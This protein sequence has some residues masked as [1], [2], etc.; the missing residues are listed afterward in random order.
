[1][2]INPTIEQLRD[3]IRRHEHQYYALDRPEIS[4]AEYDRMMRQLQE[5]ET[6]EPWLVTPD[7]PTQRVGGT[8]AA[9]FATVEHSPP[10]LSLANAF[11]L[12]DLKTWHNRCARRLG[13]DNFAMT[14]ELKFDGLALRLIYRNGRLEQAATRGNGRQG[15]DVTHTVRTIK[16]IPLVLP[17]VHSDIAVRG[18]AYLPIQSF[19]ELNRVR[20]ERGD[21]VYANPRNAAAGAIRQLDP[22]QAAERDLRFWAYSL[23]HVDF[24]HNSHWQ[25]LDMLKRATLPVCQYK[26]REHTVEGIAKFYDWMLA[27]RDNLPF[28]A[29]GIVVK[30][31]DYADQQELGETNHDPRWAIAWKFPAERQ[32]T[33]L[34]RIWVSVGRFGKMTPMADLEP[35]TLDGAVVTNAS[36]HNEGDIHRKDIRAGDMVYVERSGGVIPQ[37]V[38]PVN[39]DPNR[40]TTPFQWPSACPSCGG[41]IS[42]REPG[43]ADRWCLNVDCGSKPVA[44]LKHFVSKDA[45]DID[46]MGRVI[47]EN[48]VGTGLVNP[49]EIFT[50]TVEDLETLDKVGRKTAEKLYENIQAAKQRPMERVLYSLGIFRLGHHVSRLLA[51]RYETMDEVMALT[52]EDLVGIEGIGASIAESVLAGLQSSRV[53]ALVQELRADGVVLEWPREHKEH[54]AGALS[55]QR[56]CVTGTLSGMTRKEAEAAV[57]DHGGE[58]A[59]DVTKSTTLLVVGEKPGSKVA[60][61]ERNGVKIWSEE[62]FAAAIA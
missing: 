47:C 1:M 37:V 5:W 43:D 48:L 38:G 29:D 45:M 2:P 15:E 16:S 7:S 54:R 55:G 19:Q 51:E 41:V 33:K 18:E 50:F 46:G 56:V 61:A 8:V 9:G 11:N 52:Y 53:V 32:S 13:R 30:V 23:E 57:N 28:E 35:V 27:I 4:D 39:R 26:V 31:S 60:K 14:A 25:G 49:G 10:M 24:R 22:R 44:A 17:K 20:Q 42:Q 59:K 40:A 34:N 3:E 58:V 21:D 6:A 12:D 36:L 62:Q